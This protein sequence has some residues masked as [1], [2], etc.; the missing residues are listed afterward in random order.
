MI[1]VIV[2]SADAGRLA[3]FRLNVEA[4]IGTPYEVLAF[5]NRNEKKGIAAVYNQ[6]AAKANYEI[7][8]FVH[9]DVIIY[10]NGWGL[11]L[12][13]ILKDTAI[14]L[15]GISGAVY[16]SRYPGSWSACDQTLYRTHS[17]QHF[18]HLEKPLVINTNPAHTSLTEVAVIDGVFM[19]TRKN[20]FQ[21]FSFDAQLLK[22]FHGYDIDYSLQVG[23]QYKLVVSYEL[24]LEHLS[25]GKLSND[26]LK[27][28]LQVHKKWRQ[29]LPVQ[30]GSI[31]KEL[32]KQSDYQS[33]SCV[34]GVAIQ[35]PGNKKLA[36]KYFYYLLSYFF[37]NNK[38]RYAKS[39]SRYLFKPGN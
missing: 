21:Q 37:S 3:K 34:L 19:A 29:R 11:L 36:S 12:E 4:T 6:L 7:C 27:D 16:K 35:Y 2:C 18:K 39:V 5:D 14:G 24:L 33:C 32:R 26:W 25:E 15:V 8:C 1:S 9:E 17:I 22:G 13:K 23:R 20:I 28:S 30:I 10:T 38:F 31:T